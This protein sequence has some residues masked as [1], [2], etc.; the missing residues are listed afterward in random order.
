[1]TRLE[2]WTRLLSL[3][4]MALDLGRNRAVLGEHSPCISR[5]P[6]SDQRQFLTLVVVAIYRLSAVFLVS[7]HFARL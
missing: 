7:S 4:G 2:A 3:A 5:T 1:M 6:G